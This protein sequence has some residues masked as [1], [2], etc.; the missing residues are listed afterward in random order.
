MSD[1]E[2]WYTVNEKTKKANALISVMI[3]IGVEIGLTVEQSMDR[4]LG[5]G[6]YK[7]IVDEVYEILRKRDGR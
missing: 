7:T 1:R 2:S 5:P 4:V 6:S 3:L